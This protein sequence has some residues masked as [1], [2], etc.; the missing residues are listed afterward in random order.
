MFDLPSFIFGLCV[1]LLI[2][3]IRDEIMEAMARTRQ[4]RFKLATVF[5]RLRGS[6][7]Q[8]MKSL[9]ENKHLEITPGAA[10]TADW[11]VR[12]SP[13]AEVRPNSHER[14]IL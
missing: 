5:M 3:L 2:V 4:K 12:C 10:C 13:A 11:T 8:K 7:N 6:E 9:D 1:G 14:G